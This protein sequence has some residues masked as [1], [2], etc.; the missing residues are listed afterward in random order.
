MH[1]FLDITQHYKMLQPAGEAL[2]NVVLEMLTGPEVCAA[3]AEQKSETV[4]QFEVCFSS[5]A[6]SNTAGLW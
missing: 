5:P 3:D 2:L 1:H 6:R 4:F